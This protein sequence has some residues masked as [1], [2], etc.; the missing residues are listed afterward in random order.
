MQ[1]AD[2][3]HAAVDVTCDVRTVSGMLRRHNIPAVD[4]LKVDLERSALDVL[5]GINADDWT[6]TRQIAAEVHDEDGRLA[7]IVDVCSNARASGSTSPRPAARWDE[8]VEG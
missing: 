7:A 6:R 3:R 2:G 4:L 1:L 8:L 5:I